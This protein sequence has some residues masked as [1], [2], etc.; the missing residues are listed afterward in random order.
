MDQRGTPTRDGIK[1]YAYPI[2]VWYILA[3]TKKEED[4]IVIRN[5]ARLVA[6]GYRQ[7]EGIDFDESFVP[8]DRLEAVQ[9]FVAYVAHKSFTIYQMDVKMAFVNGPLKE[10]VYVNQQ[11]GFVDPNHPKK[12]YR[13]RKALYGLKQAPR[14]WYVELSK[15]LISK[16]FSEDIL[17]KHGMDKCDSIGTPMPTSPNLDAGDKLVSWSS[18]MQDYTAM[19][20]AEAEYVALFASCAQ[21]LWI[22]TQLKDYGFD[23][24]KIPMYSDSQSAIAFSC[25]PMQHSRTKNINIRYHFIKEQVENGIVELYFVRTEYQLADM[26]TKALLKKRFE[27]LVGRLGMRCLTPAELEVIQIVLWIIDS[28]Y[29]E[30]MTGNLKL[31]KNFIEK[32]MGTVRFRNDHFAAITGYDDYVHG[33]V[34]ISHVY[35]V[36][37]LV[38]S[39]MGKSKKATLP[40]KLVPSTH[41][42]LELIHM[43]LCGPM[44]VENINGKKYILVIVDDYSRYMW[45]TLYPTNDRE[46]VGK[47]K[48]KADIG[49]FIWYS[50]TSRRF[51][52]YN[53]RTRKI[54]K[55]I[56]VKFDELTTM[57]SEHNCLEPDTNR[58]NNDDSSDEF[59]STPSKEDL[60]NLFGPTFEKY[61]EKRSLEVFINSTAQTTLH[62]NDTSSSSSIIVE[63]NEAPPFVSSSEEQISPISTNDVVESVQE[64]S[65]DLDGNTLL[66]PYNSLMFKEAESSS[67]PKDPSNMPEFSQV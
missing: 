22:R 55:T 3:L 41:S 24:N 9:I 53:R 34:T 7:E 42:K 43:D 36:E 30:H 27:Y 49:I 8:V 14:A 64:D 4:N 28:G 18:K 16:G 60:D 11:Y 45:I 65:T 13:L 23:Y 56:H 48:Q 17:K 67:T 52:I 40:P 66:T 5:K 46:E 21:V 35:Y 38:N 61:F 25:K 6:K 12:V 19:S 37:G 59:T 50:K 44:R 39:T 10:E 51:Q 15:F 47:M 33:N 32:F 2:F 20:I 54:I 63:D 57:T 26:F 31:L 29:S 58:F 1:G 62:N